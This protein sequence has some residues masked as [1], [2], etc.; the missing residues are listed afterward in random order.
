MNADLDRLLNSDRASE[1]NEDPVLEQLRDR[2]SELEAENAGLRQ[3]DE[4][5]R[6]N[7]C[8]FEALLRRSQEGIFL[9][10]PQMT[11]L[12]M[13]HSILGYTDQD[14]AGRSVLSRIH[15]DDRVRVSEAFSRL[16]RDPSQSVLCE[17]RARDQ[18]GRWS[19]M[20]VEMTD[21]LDDPDVQA[22]VFNNR[23]ITQRRKYEEAME[24]LA[25]PCSR[26][27]KSNL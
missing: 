23:N 7:A 21:M 13:I 14:S 26:C 11:I 6:R 19:W 17:C 18:A 4:A 15:P 8:L 24:R 5:V 1:S 9:L 20:E 16:M 25:S 22:I 2:I 3:S 12:R 10:T 27:E